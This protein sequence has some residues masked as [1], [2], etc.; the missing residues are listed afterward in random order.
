MNL[1]KIFSLVLLCNFSFSQKC[2]TL[3][4]LLYNCTD[5]NGLKHGFWKE[6]KKIIY[7]S[8]HSGLGGKEG[9][10]YTENFYLKTLAEGLYFENKKVG[11]WTL[12]SE[13]NSSIIEKE[14]IFEKTGNIIEN[15]LI[16]HSQ[17]IYNNDSSKITGYVLSYQ[18]TINIFY[19][20]KECSLKLNNNY[21]ILNFKCDNFEK[22]Q[23]ELSFI[24]FGCYNK[25][26]RE[27]KYISS[28]FDQ[29]IKKLNGCWYSKYHQFKYNYKT[30]IGIEYKSKTHS[31]APIFQTIIK[32]DGAYLIWLELTGGEIS[33]KII[34]IN[35]DKL[36]IRN[37]NGAKTI[38]KRNKNCL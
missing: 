8:S 36:K 30:N 19:N 27:A 11:K 4:G 5:S 2:D 12:Y 3:E 18:D 13:N 16:D 9:C 35:D 20:N 7:G 6:Q 37:F 33:Q 24:K 1:L 26:I 15:N 25:Q 21:E 22:L 38:Y 34:F 28:K 10:I 29:T 17:I 32:K 23:M 31:S 14:V